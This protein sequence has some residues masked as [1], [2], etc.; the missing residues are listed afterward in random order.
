[1]NKE[2]ISI[3]LIISPLFLYAQSSVHFGHHTEINNQVS[4]VEYYLSIHDRN[5]HEDTFF[6]STNVQG[7]NAPN[8]NLYHVINP[9]N[10]MEISFNYNDGI[11][12]NQ[13][14][15]RANA[16]ER[17]TECNQTMLEG[18]TDPAAQ[19]VNSIASLC[20]ATYYNVKKP[21]ASPSATY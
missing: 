13:T 8:N 14:I 20:Y 21:V 10:N 15:N 7:I 17:I 5:N 18:T 16:Q 9:N 1:M 6:N 11:Y 12:D 19:D 2:L 4:Q 3:A